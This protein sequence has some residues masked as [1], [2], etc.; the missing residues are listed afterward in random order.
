MELWLVVGLIIGLVLGGRP[1]AIVT[2]GATTA[3]GHTA[4]WP[5]TS[6]STSATSEPPT[7]APTST[8]I[9]AGCT[10]RLDSPPSYSGEEE[11]R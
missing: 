10:T 7:R 8:R 4:R 3:C 6:T 1:S 11:W 9:S 2:P 5:T